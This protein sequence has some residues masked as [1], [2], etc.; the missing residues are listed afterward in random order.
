MPF[1][2]II[3]TGSFVPER[4]LTNGDLSRNLGEN[5]NDF[6]SSVIGINERHICAENESTADLATAA[7]LRALESARVA[8]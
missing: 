6:V 1:A 4:V 5:I 8:P 7:S 2:K 3:G